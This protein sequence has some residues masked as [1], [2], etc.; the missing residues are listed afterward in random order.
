MSD[1]EL[2]K[3]LLVDDEDVVREVCTAIL[4]KAGFNVTTAVNG[5]DALEK[6]KESEYDI[7]VLDVNMPK[8]DG[9]DLYKT[10]L[11]TKPDMRD[12]FLFITG[13]LGGE[14]D[15]LGVLL[16]TDILVICKPFTT[17]DF[18]ANVRQLIGR[19]T[20]QSA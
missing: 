6:I 20:E 4:K 11:K 15:A 17:E 1:K 7:V 13:N 2:V 5:L 12:R 10:V 8:L 3:V 14:L 19:V 9:I 16:Q 18:L